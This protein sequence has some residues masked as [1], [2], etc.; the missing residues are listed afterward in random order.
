MIR[1]PVAVEDLLIGATA[2]ECGMTLATRNTA[3]FDRLG[4]P[5][6]NPFE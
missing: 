2:L 3:H 5:L 4:V 1:R 6:V